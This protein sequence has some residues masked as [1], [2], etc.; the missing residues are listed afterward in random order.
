M[1]AVTLIVMVATVVVINAIQ[2]VS[3]HVLDA[4]DVLLAEAHVDQVVLLLVL[5]HATLLALIAAQIH[6]VHAAAHVQLHVLP[7]VEQ[8]VK[9]L[10]MET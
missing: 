10:V 2:R 7:I 3:N 8:H 6:A 1:E 4:V 5:E 9:I